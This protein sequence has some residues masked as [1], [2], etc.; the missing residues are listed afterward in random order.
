MTN[1]I[2]VTY[3]LNH[4]EK[5]ADYKKLYWTLGTYVNRR[6]MDSTFILKT[7]ETA[8]Q[9]HDK[10]NICLDS[11]DFILCTQIYQNTS[12]GR[13]SSENATRFSASLSWLPVRQNILR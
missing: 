9:V 3:D 7:N 2:L 12:Y 8:Q 4:Y 6:I 5:W 10:L 11:N 13:L 1:L